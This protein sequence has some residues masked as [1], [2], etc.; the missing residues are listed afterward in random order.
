M[1]HGHQVPALCVLHSIPDVGTW[2]R[3]LAASSHPSG[4][5]P[6]CATELGPAVW[7][8]LVPA[9]LTKPVLPVLHGVG[10]EGSTA[11]RRAGSGVMDFAGQHLVLEVQ[12]GCASCWP[13]PGSAFLNPWLCGELEGSR[14][15]LP[16]LPQ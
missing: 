3:S 6:A 7:Q 10:S 2:R 14:E 13:C 12:Q 1:A 11:T 8:L 9:K 16:T 4:N 15:T 5:E